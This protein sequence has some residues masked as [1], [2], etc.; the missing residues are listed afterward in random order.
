M[1]SKG[2]KYWVADAITG[3]IFKFDDAGIGA[4]IATGL[5][6]PRG[7]AVWGDISS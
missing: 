2:S 6:N 7:L 3:K 4:E 5:V 1:A